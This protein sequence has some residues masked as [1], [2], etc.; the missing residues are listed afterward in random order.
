MLKLRL[1]TLF[2][3][4]GIII[5]MYGFIN[6]FDTVMNVGA[7]MSSFSIGMILAIFNDRKDN[8]Q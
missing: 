4:I 8:L 1:A 7:L 6:H 3:V 2:L 5:E